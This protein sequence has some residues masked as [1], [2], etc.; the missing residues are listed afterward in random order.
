DANGVVTPDSA[1]LTSLTP[2]NILSVV[3]TAQPTTATSIDGN[4]NTDQAV[5]PAVYASG[6]MALYAANPATG[7]KPDFSITVPVSDSKG[8][9]RNMVVD[10]LKSSTPNQW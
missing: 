10:F 6:D 2:I 5:N 4:L 9:Q 8:G 7:V 1:N 3:N